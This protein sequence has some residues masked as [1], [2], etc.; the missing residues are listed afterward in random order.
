MTSSQPAAVVTA[1][2]K[3]VG[4][5]CAH[6]LSKR[7]YRLTIMSR[8]AGIH[9]VAT[10]TGATAMTGDVT[11]PE[12][13]E[14]LMELAIKS[15]SRIDG[16]VINTGLSKDGLP[17]TGNHY[18]NS[19]DGGLIDYDDE[20]WH[21]MFALQF[22]H[23]VRILRIVTPIMIECGGGSIVCISAMISRSP[24]ATYPSSSTIR[25]ALDGYVKLYSD[26]YARNGIRMNVV[27]PGLLDNIAWNPGHL[28]VVPMQRAGSPD[29]IAKV[30][31]FLLSQD[32]SY[33]TGQNIVADGGFIRS[34]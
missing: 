19:Q 26:R 3:G 28:D 23:V 8:S 25:R 20:F 7:G 13:L 27:S 2:S 18:D 33:I 15:H 1:A 24:H 5:A 12:D 22:M 16:V 31:A 4:A 10:A 29:E 32:S 34:I 9:G 11:N 17:F 30:V 14:K 21:E 6:E